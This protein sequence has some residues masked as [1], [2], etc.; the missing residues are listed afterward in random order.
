MSDF[1]HLHAVILCDDSQE[2]L[3]PLTRR[4][5]PRDLLTLSGEDGS[6]VTRLVD[7]CLPLSDGQVHIVCSSDMLPIY[8]THLLAPNA[9]I[10]G[11]LPTTEGRFDAEKL[12]FIAIPPHQGDTFAIALIA[13]YLRRQDPDAVL[14][15]ARSGVH[16]PADELWESAVS[17]A[18]EAAE[19]EYL[20]LIGVQAAGAPASS[21]RQTMRTGAELVGLPGVFRCVEYSEKGTS[22]S[23]LS[24]PRTLQY[25]GIAVMRANVLISELHAT[26][27]RRTQRDGRVATE[28]IDGA[29][30]AEMAGFLA[31]LGRE[32]WSQ[33]DAREV[34][35]NLPDLPIGI[36]L[37]EPSEHTVV[38]ATEL[39]WSDVSTLSALA[40]LITTH[41]EDSGAIGH[42][43][44]IAC[45]NTT[46]Y[47]GRRL[48]VACGLQDVVVVDT[49]DVT[50][51][52]DASSI[53]DP[54]SYLD[55][56]E[57][58]DMPELQHG[59]V[60]HRAW[61]TLETLSHE[62]DASVVR[63]TVT[64]GHA[65]PERETSDN[66]QLTVTSGRGTLRVN[67]TSHRLYPQASHAIGQHARW[68]LEARTDEPLAC[69]VVRM[70]ADGF[71]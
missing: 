8:R 56:L 14:L 44:S 46:V 57:E 37:F 13:A 10:E 24:D 58:L 3:W 22:A 21:S 11:D 61:G 71:C 66:L 12:D 59:A 7:A 45:T 19:H 48:V 54:S 62:E 49:P 33:P 36:S 38:V 20:A 39:D 53:A 69:V 42:T 15:V 51:V 52:A 35:A 34:I 50:L 4:D 6:L 64:P 28:E 32:Y 29:R 25:C 65:I 27:E 31:S 9:G 1:P 47:G 41:E 60:E 63:L 18:Y 40:R 43:E 17:R 55:R 30:I 2:S 67:G 16:F 68:S 26:Q 70:K 23:R 5:T